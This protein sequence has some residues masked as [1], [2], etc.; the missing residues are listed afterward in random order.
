MNIQLPNSREADDADRG[1][2]PMKTQNNEIQHGQ[3]NEL[4]GIVDEL[5]DFLEGIDLGLLDRIVLAR[6]VDR[7]RQQS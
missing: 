1:S 3:E 6:I 4:G 5:E 2:L 7:L